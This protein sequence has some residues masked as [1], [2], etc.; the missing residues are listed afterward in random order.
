MNYMLDMEYHTGLP[1]ASDLSVSVYE[2][3]PRKVGRPVA[4]KAIQRALKKHGF[5]LV[6][7]K[8]VAYARSRWQQDPKFTPYPATWYNQERY[9]DAPETWA[10]GNNGSNPSRWVGGADAQSG[11]VDDLPV[12]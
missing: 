10:N 8:T 2:A 6:M 9:M 11:E 7:E 1:S 5:K 3:Y 12:S 4:L